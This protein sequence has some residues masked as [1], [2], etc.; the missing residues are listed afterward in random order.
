M[1]YL[2]MIKI[3]KIMIVIIIV[4]FIYQN[5]QVQI[6]IIMNQKHLIFHLLYYLFVFSFVHSTELIILINFVLLVLPQFLNNTNF[7]LHQTYLFSFLHYSNFTTTSFKLLF[8]LLP[9]NLC[10]YF[11]NEI[12]IDKILTYFTL[13]ELFFLNY[14]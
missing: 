1:V 9:Y 3:M 10:L 8:N 11:L 4:I 7:Y 5:Y 6:T 14:I 2:Q 12:F 13:Y